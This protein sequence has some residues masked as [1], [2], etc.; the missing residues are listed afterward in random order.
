MSGGYFNYDDY[1][2]NY[3]IETLEEVI[4][5]NGKFKERI[6]ESVMYWTDPVEV[7]PAYD[8]F[9]PEHS[10]EVLALCKEAIQ[11]CKRALIYLHRLD[12]Y[13]SSDDEEERL[14]KRLKEDLEELD[15]AN[16]SG[17]SKSHGK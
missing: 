16:S 11:L 14:F 7:I 17:I 6:P 2:L 13:L 12:W 3:I 10:P 15:Y 5:R 4:E 9:Y 8:S 1:R